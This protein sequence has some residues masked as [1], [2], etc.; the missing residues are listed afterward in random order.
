LAD[1][2]ISD[3]KI[4]MAAQELANLVGKD[5]DLVN[6]ENASTVFKAQ[7]LGTGEIIY[8]QQPQKR[9]GLHFYSTLLTSDPPLMWLHNV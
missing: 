9:K 1:K 3:Y 6:L 7:V 5:F 2:K 8:D 4:F